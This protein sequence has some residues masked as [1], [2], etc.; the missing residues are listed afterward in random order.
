[1]VLVIACILRLLVGCDVFVFGYLLVYCLFLGADDLCLLKGCVF[2]VCLTC[3]FVYWMI[4][5]WIVDC[6]CNSVAFF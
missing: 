5:V 6:L 1:M 4:F 3:V 2:W